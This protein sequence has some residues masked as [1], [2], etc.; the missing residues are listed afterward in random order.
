MRPPIPAVRRMR[1]SIW[2]TSAAANGDGTTGL[3]VSAQGKAG[4]SAF[5]ASLSGKGLADRLLEAP[6]SLTFKRQEYRR[7]RAAGALR[8][9]GAAA[10][11]GWRGDHRCFGERHAWRR[12]GD[13]LQPHRRR[14]QGRFRRDDR[15]HADKAPTAK[16]KVSLEAADIEPWLMTTGIGLPG[17]GTGM[18]VVACGRRRLTATAC[19]CCPAS[20]APSTR[21]RFPATS[22]S[23]SRTG[24]RILTGALALDELDLDPMAAMVLGDQALP[25]A[26]EGLA[27]RPVQPEGQRCRS[28][29]DLDLDRGVA[30]RPARLP[31]PMTRRCR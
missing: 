22:M 15:Q 4:G 10:R 19:W 6:V 16:G 20:A 11:H 8:P 26:G 12:H 5:S 18:P 1:A 21:V 27:D 29:A 13:E 2:S 14:L 7:H 24:C 31:R 23:T 25:G 28:R 9:A 17:M 3:A 30:G